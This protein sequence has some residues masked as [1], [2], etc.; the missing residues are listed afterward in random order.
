MAGTGPL[1]QGKDMCFIFLILDAK[2]PKFTY[3]KFTVGFCYLALNAFFV[4]LLSE[5]NFSSVKIIILN[6]FFVTLNRF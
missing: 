1:I 4:A 6:D 2:I 5:I 3:V